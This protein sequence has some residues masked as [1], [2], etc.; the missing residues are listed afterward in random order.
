[1]IEASVLGKLD[2]VAI[3]LLLR[4]TRQTNVDAK[5]S[6]TKGAVVATKYDICR[7]G[8]TTRVVQLQS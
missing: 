6:K 8:N 1:M 7:R 5:Q 2:C 3:C 4:T